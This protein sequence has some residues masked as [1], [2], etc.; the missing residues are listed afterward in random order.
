MLMQIW[1]YRITVVY[2]TVHETKTNQ[3]SKAN[4]IYSELIL[5]KQSASIT[6]TWQ[7]LKGRQQWEK[8]T[9]RKRKFSDMP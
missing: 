5:A 9:L 1:F 3:V 2:L 4:S 7:L 6:C 8:F